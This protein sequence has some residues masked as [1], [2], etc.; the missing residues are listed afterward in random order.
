MIVAAVTEIVK[1]SEDFVL[2]LAHSNAACDELAARL[3]DVLQH[4]QL[5]RL[6]AKYFNKDLIPA[7]IRHCCN[8]ENENLQF[9]ALKLLYKFRVVVSTLLTAGSLVRT[10]GHDPDFSSSHFSR[11][12]IDEAGCTHE[13]ATLIPIAGSYL[14]FKV[15]ISV[16]NIFYVHCN[17]YII[18]YFSYFPGL[19]SELG[20]VKAK[21]VLA[22]DPNQLDAVT[23]SRYATDL[24]Y[25]T[26]F[27]EYLMNTKKCYSHHPVSK[28]RHPKFINVL[29][30]NY[31]SHSGILAI[32]NQLFYG[33]VL[34]AK[35]NPGM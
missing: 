32:P 11:I 28:Q 8:L 14:R 3:V 13:P 9:P 35:G 16:K 24:G 29:T 4:G 25:G 1:G 15:L 33:G 31:R 22:G 23:K 21:I 10:R 19:C 18:N 30:K 20:E 34:E 26:S 7:K 17:Q 27:M 5:L 6:Y 12:F 2:V